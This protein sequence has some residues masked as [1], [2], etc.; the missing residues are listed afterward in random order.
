MLRRVL[1]LGLAAVY[2]WDQPHLFWGWKEL[3]QDLSFNEITAHLSG[4]P[5]LWFVASENGSTE[6][7]SLFDL[8]LARNEYRALS[9][10]V[11]GK[12]STFESPLT[13]RFRHSNIDWTAHLNRLEAIQDLLLNAAKGRF[14]LVRE[15]LPIAQPQIVAHA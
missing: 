8:S 13:D 5:Y 1:E 10:T 6:T 2:L 12:F 11:H 7:I 15:H 9:N 14:A 3:D 4:Q